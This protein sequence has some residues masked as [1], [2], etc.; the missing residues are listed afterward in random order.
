MYKKNPTFSPF[1]PMS[2]KTVFLNVK[3]THGSVVKDQ[4]VNRWTETFLH[5][6]TIS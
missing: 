6:S 3:K 1:P 2:T 5:T 4:R